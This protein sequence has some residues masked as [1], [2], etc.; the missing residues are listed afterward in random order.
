M[1]TKIV[2]IFVFI[3]LI[4]TAIIYASETLNN[5]E[6]IKENLEYVTIVPIS[7]TPGDIESKVIDGVNQKFNTMS[8]VKKDLQALNEHEKTQENGLH[9][10]RET[11]D[12]VIITTEE[13]T[14]EITSSDFI[15]WKTRLGY[16]VKIVLKTDSEIT[17]QPGDDFPERM[18]N[19]LREY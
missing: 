19:F 3:I 4:A 5:Q 10:S 8:S 15:D 11:Y 2:G 9:Q 14:D 1:I 18:R 7:C 16:S 17:S 12:Y 6:S 13:L